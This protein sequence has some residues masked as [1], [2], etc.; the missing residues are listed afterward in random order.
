M[1]EVW[2]VAVDLEPLHDYIPT[3]EK[4]LVM[5][6]ATE[7]TRCSVLETL[8]ESLDWNHCHQ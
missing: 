1:R 7:H 4:K 5:G 2:L 8:V 6:D 3:I